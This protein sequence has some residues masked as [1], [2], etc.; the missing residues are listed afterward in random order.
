M[1]RPVKDQHGQLVDVAVLRL[2]ELGQGRCR[3]VVEIDQLVRQPVADGDLVHVGVGCGEEAAFLRHRQHG[4]RVGAAGC[5][6]RRAFQR[7]EGDIEAGSLAGAHGLADEE[8]RRLVPLAFADHHRAVDVERVEAAPHGIDG[9]LIRGDL[10]APADQPGRRAGRGL[11]HA[12]RVQRQV[13]VEGDRLLC[14]GRPLERFDPDHARRLQYRVETVDGGERV[15][16]RRLLGLVGGEHHRH[17]IAG[18]ASAL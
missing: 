18:V 10:V 17:Q 12:H 11:G 14:H 6:N 4:E 1:P 13:A 9:G 2:G 16:H 15:H 5:A 7:V 3:R 8:H